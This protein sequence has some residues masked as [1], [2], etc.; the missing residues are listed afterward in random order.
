MRRTSLFVLLF[1]LLFSGS[2]LAQPTVS[3]RGNVGAAFFQSPTS[4]NTVLD[5]GFD[6][7]LETGI[8][9]YGG[10]ELALQGSYD[11]FS[12]NE[13]NAVL[14]DQ[15]L[16]LGN[17]STVEGGDLYLLN[18]ALGLRYILLRESDVRPYVTGGVGFYRSA[19]TQAN[20]FQEGILV[21]SESRKG[22]TSTGIHVGVGM[23]FHVND[24]YIVFFEPRYV[25]VQ[26]TSR[27]FGFG[28][29]TRFV[30]VRLGLEM[31]F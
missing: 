9:L 8:R 7:G 20:I 30:P 28:S 19:I 22:T 12:L 2:A 29:F 26:T 4:L 14:L 17:G 5:S 16:S 6:L 18:V 24:T 27:E 21:E 25:I 13:D 3:V 11:R 23:N 10:L 31:R 1:A 15:N